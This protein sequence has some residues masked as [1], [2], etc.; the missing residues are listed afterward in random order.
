MGKAKREEK[1]LSSKTCVSDLGCMACVEVMIGEDVVK[2]RRLNHP[3]RTILFSL[4]EWQDFVC[5]IKNGDFDQSP[6]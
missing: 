2:I 5:G 3:R 6:Q 4:G 1:W